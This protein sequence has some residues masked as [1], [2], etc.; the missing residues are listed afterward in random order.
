M[1]GKKRW[2]TDCAKAH[3]GAEVIQGSVALPPCTTARPLHTRYATIFGASV[4]KSTMRPNPK[5]VGVKKCEVCKKTRASWSTVA[6]AR[7]ARDEADRRPWER[8]EVSL[9]LYPIVTS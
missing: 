8:G 6:D 3:P 4:S 5:V 7:D 2:C 9:G 1:L